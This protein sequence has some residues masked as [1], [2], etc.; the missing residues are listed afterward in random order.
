M[1]NDNNLILKDENNTFYLEF[2][3]LKQIHDYI[4]NNILRFCY[5]KYIFIYNKDNKIKEYKVNIKD[6]II[7][8]TIHI[9]NLEKSNNYKFNNYIK[10]IDKENIKLNI[11]KIIKK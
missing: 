1:D 5:L 7:K 2:N 6:Y 11:E 3:N 9:H 10:E 8:N 4:K